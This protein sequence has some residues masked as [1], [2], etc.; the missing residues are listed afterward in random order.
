[1]TE[2]GQAIVLNVKGLGGAKT[3]TLI[4][5]PKHVLRRAS[6][7]EIEKYKEPLKNMF[8]SIGPIDHYFEA[9]FEKQIDPNKPG[10]VNFHPTE[11]FEKDWK[12][13]VIE[14]KKG[15][16]QPILKLNQVFLLLDKE[17][18][19]GPQALFKDS[20]TW[21]S[22]Q[23]FLSKGTI[24]LDEDFYLEITD[25]D[26]S[27]IRRTYEMLSK[28]DDKIFS[29]TERIEQFYSLY[30]LP[31]HSPFRVL[32]YFS[33]IESILTHPPNPTDRF[34]S[35]TRQ[36]TYKF[37]LLNNRLDNRIIYSEFFENN[38]KNETVWKKLYKIRSRIA[39]G[40]KFDFEKEFQDF[41]D[42]PNLVFFL[43]K[44]VKRI[45]FQSL[46]EPKLMRDLK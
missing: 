34:D 31:L 22:R 37:N 41:K 36:I 46:L 13:F 20:M 44:V 26:A 40:G 29:L 9:K 35:I 3:R 8:G 24:Y 21:P 45:L 42:L 18:L 25:K 1:M 10:T 33:L 12:Y 39:H 43:H 16:N 17:I 11:L 7:S 32:G 38:P 14:Y 5:S 19:I 28:H 30:S 23:Y 27:L 4:S 2:G 15:Q 6:K